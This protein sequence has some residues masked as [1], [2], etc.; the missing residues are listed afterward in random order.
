M[1]TTFHKSPKCPICRGSGKTVAEDM[2]L[3]PFCSARCKRIDLA[4]WLSE[5]YSLET[6]PWQDWNP[7]LTEESN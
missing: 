7:D 4:Q 1:V 5:G 2:D 3:T 6:N